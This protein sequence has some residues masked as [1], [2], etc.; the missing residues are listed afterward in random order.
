[1]FSQSSSLSSQIHHNSANHT[2]NSVRNSANNLGTQNTSGDPLDSN[3]KQF[4]NNTNSNTSKHITTNNQEFQLDETIQF[5]PTQ[6][7]FVQPVFVKIASLHSELIA[8]SKDGKLYQWKW[9]SNQPFFNSQNDKTNVFHP[10]TITL[11]LL[12]EKIVG[13]S[14]SY[15][16]ASLW[17][18][19]G[20]VN[21]Y[22]LDILGD[23]LYCLIEIQ[24]KIFNPYKPNHIRDKSK[25]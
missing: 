13:I 24:K 18:E 1:M 9:K 15:M 3:E 17:T 19:T 12:N 4:Q 21:V 22:Y 8:I 2:N 7:Y 11:N 10:K 16:R 5:W 6:T 14:T 20:K 23:T 25:S